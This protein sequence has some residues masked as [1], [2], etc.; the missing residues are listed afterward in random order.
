MKKGRLLSLSQAACLFRA[1]AAN[2]QSEGLVGTWMVSI[3]LHNCET[4]ALRIVGTFVGTLAW[5]GRGAYVFG[6]S[7]T[8]NKHGLMRTEDR[9]IRM[10]MVPT[11]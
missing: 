9:G 4:G 6:A 3:T 8:P 1:T 2:A 7:S 11:G 10:S 5:I